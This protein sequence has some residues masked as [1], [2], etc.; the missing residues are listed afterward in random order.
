MG[1]DT[2]DIKIRSCFKHFKTYLSVLGG[3]ALSK[4]ASTETDY[5]WEATF[6]NLPFWFM[7]FCIAVYIQ[8]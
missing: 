3:L 4:R 7:A 5:V 2:T 1:M 6:C 8:N